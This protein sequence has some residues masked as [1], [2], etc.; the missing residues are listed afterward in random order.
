MQIFYELNKNENL[1][2]ALGYFDGVHSGHKSVI[3]SAVKFAKANNIKTAVLTFK[4]HPCCYLW[5]M[6]PKYILTR[7]SREEKIENLGVDYLYELDFETIGRFSADEYLKNILIKYF[8]PRA[9]SA[10]WNHNFGCNKSGNGDFLKEKAKKYGYEY[11]EIQ[12]EIYENDIISSTKI[13]DCLTNG[14]IEFANSMLGY[15]FSIS[16]VVVK[17]QQI[18]RKIG[19]RTANINYPNELIELP[20][21][22]YSVTV[23]YAK[24]NYKGIANFGIRPTV[25]GSNAI[26]EV[27][28]LDFDKDIYG[29]NIEVFFNKMIRKEQKFNS[30]DEL[31]TQIKSDIAH[32]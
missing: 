1:S 10:G 21:G 29:E 20:Y 23:K 11:F 6:C 3:K 5:G 32:I 9:I 16:G 12:P 13:R 24:N 4:E 27:H 2:L 19:F 15:K 8:S 7:K 31:K 28:I 26:L 18:G 22:V 17:G 30:L 14:N 25:N